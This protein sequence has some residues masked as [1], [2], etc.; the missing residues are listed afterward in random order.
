MGGDPSSM[1][2]TL[3]GRQVDLDKALPIV[4]RDVRALARRGVD[5]ERVSSGKDPIEGPFAIA[6]YLLQ[7][8]DPSVSE[9]E[10]EALRPE[11]FGKLWADLEQAALHTEEADRPLSRPSTSSPEP[12]DGPSGT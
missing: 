8:A 5:L 12:S 10:L 1:L 2:V 7:K 11:E 6:L 4:M 9:A 3:N